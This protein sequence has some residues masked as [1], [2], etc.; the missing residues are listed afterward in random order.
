M[1]VELTGGRQIGFDLAADIV[2]FTP[3]VVRNHMPARAHAAS[4]DELARHAA[5]VAGLKDPLWLS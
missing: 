4:V 5:F 3:A 1:Y 2:E